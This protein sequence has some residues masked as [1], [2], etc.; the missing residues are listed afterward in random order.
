MRRQILVV[1][2]L[3]VVWIDLRSLRRSAHR[4]GQKH[5]VG[6]GSGRCSSCCHHTPLPLYIFLSPAL[7]AT[8]TF[9]PIPSQDYK[10]YL[11]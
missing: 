8:K 6:G 2:K 1:S 11:E 10:P 5:G 3:I 9:I 4:G 7:H